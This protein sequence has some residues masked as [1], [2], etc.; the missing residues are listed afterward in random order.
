MAIDEIANRATLR[1]LRY[2]STTLIHCKLLLCENVLPNGTETLNSPLMSFICSLTDMICN[3]PTVYN[4]QATLVKLD[5]VLR[6]NLPWTSITSRES[7]NTN[8]LCYWNRNP[9]KFKVATKILAN[10]K[11]NNHFNLQNC[12]S[13]SSFG[14]RSE[15][16]SMTYK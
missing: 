5:K 16:I 12:Y 3:R 10:S 7:N 1:F 2:S 15:M 8:H 9:L 11:H 4:K 6:G 14:N 13:L